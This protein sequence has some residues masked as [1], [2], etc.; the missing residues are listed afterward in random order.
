MAQAASVKPAAKVLVAAFGS[1]SFSKVVSLEKGCHT[2]LSLNP[3]LLLGQLNR[4]ARP[5]EDWRRVTEPAPAAAKSRATGQSLTTSAVR[6]KFRESGS[7][8]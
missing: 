8:D 7:A 4:N 2:R 3:G 6:R 5:E 1:F